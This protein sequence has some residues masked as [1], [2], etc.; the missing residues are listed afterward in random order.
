MIKWKG[1]AEIENTWEPAENLQC[2]GMINEFEE[3]AKTDQR[4]HSKYRKPSPNVR[5]P[6]LSEVQN[7]RLR[8]HIEL[9]LCRRIDYLL[10][11]KLDVGI[12]KIFFA[13]QVIN[14]RSPYLA[15][16]GTC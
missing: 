11:K 9:K 10:T 12:W 16:L 2:Y 14:I 13:S 15:I 8:H 3:K 7:S 6:I 4:P 1:Y 5:I